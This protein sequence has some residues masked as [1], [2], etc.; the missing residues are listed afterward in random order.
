M[1]KVKT[2]RKIETKTRKREKKSFEKSTPKRF[3]R[4][5]KH[6]GINK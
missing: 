1:K 4:L 2:E 3:R 6:A 5:Q